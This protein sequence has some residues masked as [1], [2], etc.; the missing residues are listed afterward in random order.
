MFFGNE[1]KILACWPNLKILRIIK[2]HGRLR[3]NA[4]GQANVEAAGQK[5]MYFFNEETGMVD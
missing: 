1:G 2:G 5:K 3:Q 4:G